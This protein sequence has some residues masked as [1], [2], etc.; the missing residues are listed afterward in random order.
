MERY[1]KQ[2]RRNIVTVY[3]KHGEGYAETVRK[4]R[5]IF[6]RRNATYQSTVKRMIKKFEETG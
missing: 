3:Y 1:I 4:V 6:G 5:R 2:L